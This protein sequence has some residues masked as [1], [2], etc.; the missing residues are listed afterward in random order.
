MVSKIEAE[1]RQEK[2]AWLRSLTS[3][4]AA[5]AE[6][7]NFCAANTC[8]TLDSLIDHLLTWLLA[9]DL[10]RVKEKGVARAQPPRELQLQGCEGLVWIYLASLHRLY[11][12]FAIVC[13]FSRTIYDHHHPQTLIPA[14]YS[15]VAASNNAHAMAKVL[16]RSF[17]R[18]QL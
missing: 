1:D 3:L 13:S 4:T 5:I 15:T 14:H 2:I 9:P 18:F 7:M 8:L 17:T 6:R 11:E 16:G 10:D 12:Y